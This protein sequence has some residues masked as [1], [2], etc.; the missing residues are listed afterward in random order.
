M[1]GSRIERFVRYHKVLTRERQASFD[2]P[3]RLFIIVVAGLILYYAWSTLQAKYAVTSLPSAVPGTIGDI[4]FNWFFYGMV[5]GA[6]LFAFLFEG[7][8]FLGLWK[9]ASGVQK[10]VE[11]EAERLLMGGKK[12]GGTGPV[13]RNQAGKGGKR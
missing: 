7:E 12:A 6:L 9:L 4:L 8:Y 11:R 13:G 10:D 1:A 3:W 5:L 2:A